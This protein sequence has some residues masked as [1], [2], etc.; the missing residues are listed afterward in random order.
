[1]SARILR[2]FLVLLCVGCFVGCEGEQGPAGPAGPSVL[3]A[4]A[5]VNVTAGSPSTI[6]MFSSGPEGVI[7]TGTCRAIGDY[8]MTV[9][10]SFP[11]QTGTLLV[12]PSSQDP[13]DKKFVTGHITAWTTT[14]ITFDVN[15][16]TTSGTL[17]EEDFS[18]AILGR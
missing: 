5:D 1:M 6:S 13:I 14:S 2:V 18:F 11:D 16:Y 8:A 10:G 7:V 4:Y 9:V 3:L 12:S 15:A 17:S